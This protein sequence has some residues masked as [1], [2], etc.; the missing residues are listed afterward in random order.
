MQGGLR[1]LLR[2]NRLIHRMISDRP[3]SSLGRTAGL[4]QP[5]L[6]VRQAE[7]TPSQ[8]PVSVPNNPSRTA[9]S[10]DSNILLRAAMRVET[11]SA[12][13]HS[14]FTAVEPL[15]T[16]MGRQALHCHKLHRL[17]LPAAHTL[18][19]NNAIRNK[20]PAPASPQQ[21]P[22][23]HT[24]KAIYNNNS[25]SRRRRR[26]SN[27]NRNTAC[28]LAARSQ[29]V[30]RAYHPSVN[31]HS[32]PRLWDR[33]LLASGNRQLRNKAPTTLSLRVHTNNVSPLLQLNPIH[34][35]TNNRSAQS[36][37]CRLVNQSIFHPLLV[38]PRSRRRFHEFPVTTA[39]MT[40]PLRAS[41]TDDPSRRHR[42]KETA[43]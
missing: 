6:S 13:L 33:R 24:H 2:F 15:R 25:S 4:R 43:V 17:A 11:A 16:C 40:T 9:R 1:R 23:L 12:S 34:N 21:H 26:N 3:A 37:N 22:H 36:S 20:E 27:N 38:Y 42:A 8:L 19:F 30:T 7:D 31:N 18:T 29:R 5:R 35:H 10:N 14:R 39:F 32:H 28:P 41:Y